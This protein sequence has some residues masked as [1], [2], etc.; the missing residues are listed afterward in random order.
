MLPNAQKAVTE[1]RRASAGSSARWAHR[2]A[3]CAGTSICDTYLLDETGSSSSK[4]ERFVDPGLQKKTTEQAT[5]IADLKSQLVDAKRELTIVRKQMSESSVGRPSA[6]SSAA[7][8]ATGDIGK[9][10]DAYQKV[11]VENER[12]RQELAP[13]D[14]DF[15]EEIENLKFS[16]A[17]A[18]RKLRAYESQG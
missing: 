7:M 10:R 13:F 2:S 4:K 15:F 3:A 14:F 6:A 12:L 5:E 11:M 1:A 16:Y 8:D 18:Q 17:E 9:L